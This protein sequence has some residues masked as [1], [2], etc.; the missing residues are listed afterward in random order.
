MREIKYLRPLLG[1]AMMIGMSIGILNAQDATAILDKAA[2]AYENSGGMKVDFTMKTGSN[3]TAY[4]GTLDIKGDKFVLNTPDMVTWYDGKTQWSYVEHNEEVNVTTPA[5]DELQMI[6]PLLLL[7]TY[8]KN[9]TAKYDGESTAIGGKMAYN[10]VLVP[11]RKGDVTEVTLQ[12]GKS[13]NL[14]L[15]IAL[16]AQNGTHTL[17]RVKKLTTDINQADKFF[18]FDKKLYPEAEIVD[19]R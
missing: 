7:R 1:L 13:S 12:I 9:F 10:V 19:L 8:K 18:V 16:V 17:I 4:D 11:K 3:G 14:P 2:E 6:N 5:G 15:S